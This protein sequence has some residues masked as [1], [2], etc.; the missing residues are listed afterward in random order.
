MTR[1]SESDEGGTLV[2]VPEIVRLP[3]QVIDVPIARI[4]KDLGNVDD[5]AQSLSVYG[6]MHPIQV[7]RSGN[8][9][10][11]I[12]GE[13]RLR[14]A[15]QLGWTQIDA[16][17]HGAPD[18][19]LLLELMENTQRKHLGDEEE[20]DA[21]IELV[22]A[23]GYEVKAIAPRVGRSEAYVSKRVRVFED[24]ILRKSVET[25]SIPVSLAEEFLAIPAARRGAAVGRA[26]DERWDVPRARRELRNLL[27]ALEKPAVPSLQSSFTVPDEHEPTRA[28][29]RRHS[30]RSNPDVGR[31]PD[32][33]RDVRA[34]ARTLKLKRPADLTEADE[35]A[36]A[37]LL[38]VLLTL[39]RVHARA[40]GGGPV[41]PS[42]Q[43]AELAA[44]LPKR[45]VR[46][47]KR[48]QP[49]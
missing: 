24:P 47:R 13:R 15:I 20:A 22:R 10:R 26:V 38:R 46:R 30:A 44:R 34:L 1:E 43:E 23:R 40:S 37:Q 35:R 14:A 28:V 16:R 29:A 27:P 33:A 49:R 18:T 31:A 42:I 12:A 39:A 48:A 4:R 9:Y 6:L 25:G 7:Y 11:L 17:I 19:D 41:F 3:V 21:L 32:F 45:Q 8:R 36:L 2:V 5:L